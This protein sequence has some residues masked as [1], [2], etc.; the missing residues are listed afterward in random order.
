MTI[1]V[2]LPEPLPRLSPDGFDSFLEEYAVA[3]YKQRVIG[4]GR[5]AELLGTDRW[6]MDKVLLRH[7]AWMLDEED[8]RQEIEAAN[9]LIQKSRLQG[10]GG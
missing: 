10:T 1:T 2:D 8:V 6:T 5:A 4:I 7:E 3:L 9:Q